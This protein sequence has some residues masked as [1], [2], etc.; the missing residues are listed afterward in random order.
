MVSAVLR[1]HRDII[2][3]P[4]VADVPDTHVPHDEPVHVGDDVQRLV[5]SGDIAKNG[6]SAPG[7]GEAFRL[8]DRDGIHVLL[9]P[10]SDDHFIHYLLLNLAILASLAR[11]REPS[12]S[13]CSAS[14]FLI[15]SGSSSL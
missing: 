2:D 7:G 3:I 9:H 15:Y 13:F 11:A 4:L 6:I 10:L 12:A 1:Q 5:I 8:D 14:V